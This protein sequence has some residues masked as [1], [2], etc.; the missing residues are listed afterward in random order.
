MNKQEF[1][2]LK[3]DLHKHH[4]L[5]EGNACTSHPIFMVQK[6]NTIWGIDPEFDY[7]VSE[8]WYDEA[9]QGYNGIVDFLD[10]Q[11]EDF[12]GKHI[13]A[14]CDFVSEDYESGM[15]CRDIVEEE[16]D[17]DI[18]K[19]EKDFVEFFQEEG[20][21]INISY[22]RHQWEDITLFFTREKAEEF[23]NEFKYRHGKL[24]V[25]VKSGW[26]SD[27][28]KSLIESILDGDLVW[29]E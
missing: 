3:S 19:T 18:W 17:N 4:I 7:D 25:Y 2:N 21:E 24:R 22:G 10:S 27:E 15:T 11:D 29:K 28:Y 1:E 8:I 26:E 14:L 9:C 20:V 5:C 13:Q 12:D 23:C 6:R 16:L